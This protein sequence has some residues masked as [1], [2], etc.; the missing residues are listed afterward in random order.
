MRAH[1]FIKEARSAKVYDQRDIDDVKYAYDQG[2]TYADIAKLLDLSVND[3]S[4]ILTRQYPG[5]ERRAEHL[6]SA[7]TMDDKVAI[8]LAFAD[9]KTIDSI[10]HDLGIAQSLVR[11]V[12]R[13]EWGDDTVDQELSARRTTPGLQ[14]SHKITTDMMAKMREMYADGKGPTEI[15]IAL[16]AVVTP[17]SIIHALRKQEDYDQLR[18]KYDARRKARKQAAQKTATIYRPGTIGN[19]RSK[20]PGSRHMYG[21]FS[22]YE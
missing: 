17:T 1:E 21:R 20:G 8:T 14:I 19:L 11:S 12:L 9:G 3:V 6:G 16:D 15:S 10:A 5:R 18:A 7:L 22:R 13:G 2:H 4:N